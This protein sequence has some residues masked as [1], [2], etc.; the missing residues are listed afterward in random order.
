RNCGEDHLPGNDA[1]AKNPLL[2]IDVVDEFVQGMN[3]LLQ[4]AFDVVPIGGRNDS[5]NQVEREDPFRAGRVSINVESDAQLKK[6]AFG[7]V[8][9]TQKMPV[10]QRFDRLE[11]KLDVR[12]GMP[13]AL[14]HL[15]EKP[16]RPVSGKVHF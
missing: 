7:G 12:P 13:V 4:A 8:F 9:I 14:E 6:Q 3:A 10:G 11:K 1:I 15:V 2:V 5:W 16:L